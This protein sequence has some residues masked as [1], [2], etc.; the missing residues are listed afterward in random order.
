MNSNHRIYLVLI[1]QSY[2]IYALKFRS[3]VNSRIIVQ[4]QPLL[5]KRR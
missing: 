5:T 4:N 2:K 3:F 1:A